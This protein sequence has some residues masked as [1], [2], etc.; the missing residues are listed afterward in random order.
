V[1]VAYTHDRPPVDPHDGRAVRVRVTRR[2]YGR[3]GCWELR[4]AEPKRQYFT[5]F[6]RAS[7]TDLYASGVSVVEAMGQET[8]V[9]YRDVRPR[10]WLRGSSLGSHLEL[11][12]SDPGRETL[13]ALLV[14][15]KAQGVPVSPRDGQILEELPGARLEGGR[16]SI[17]LPERPRGS[18][19]YVKLFFKDAEAAR[20]VRLLPAARDELWLG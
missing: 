2:E 15:G 11:T 14:V 1:L 3:A 12:C 13:P 16:S 5:V 6:A 7:G 10:R 18:G 8:D 9:S 20:E 19:I 4:G 17:A